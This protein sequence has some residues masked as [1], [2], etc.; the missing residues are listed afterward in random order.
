MGWHL[1]DYRYKFRGDSAGWYPEY[2]EFVKALNTIK[3]RGPLCDWIDFLPTDALESYMVEYS[4]DCVLDRWLG[5][6]SSRAVVSPRL[7]WGQC[8]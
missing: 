7:S 4:I 5:Q 3:T 6:S 1:E 8:T 2:W